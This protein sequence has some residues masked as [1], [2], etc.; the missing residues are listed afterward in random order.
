VTGTPA[1]E[2]GASESAANSS[3]VFG[4]SIREVP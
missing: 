1:D 4:P 3:I 2:V